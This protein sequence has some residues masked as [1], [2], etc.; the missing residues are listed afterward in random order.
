[1]HI[2]HGIEFIASGRALD[3]TE[4]VLAALDKRYREYGGHQNISAVYAST[5]Q[6]APLYGG[7]PW[8]AY[9]SL[10]QQQIYELYDADIGLDL[11]LSNHFFTD[12]AYQQSRALLAAHHRKNNGVIC[13]NDA[14]ALRIRDDFPDY[15]LRTS[16]VKRIRTAD[17]IEKA[18]ELYDFVT[19]NMRLNDDVELMKS[20]VQKERVV[21]FANAA[22]AY[23]CEN[24]TCYIGVSQKMM[25]KEVTL[26]CSRLDV[27]YHDPLHRFDLSAE[28]LQGF[29]VFKLVEGAGLPSELCC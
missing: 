20:I 3:K 14:L 22:C 26:E 25:N 7:R 16:M 29:R 6:L 1:M 24:Q 13:T 8:T 17:Q 28:H 27:K 11:T 9:N 21:L 5:E 23:H 19:L 10:N 15:R 12:E 2:P 4:P 18:L